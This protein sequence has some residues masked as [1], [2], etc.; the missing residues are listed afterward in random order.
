MISQCKMNKQIPCGTAIVLSENKFALP[1]AILDYCASG[2]KDSSF[3]TRFDSN[4]I[5]WVENRFYVGKM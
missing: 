3:I 2:K 5:K 1:D 4:F